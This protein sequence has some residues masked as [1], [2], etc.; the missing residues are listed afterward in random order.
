MLLTQQR[1][2]S[3]RPGGHHML[4]ARWSNTLR[5]KLGIYFRPREDDFPN[6]IV[7][8]WLPQTFFPKLSRS[9]VRGSLNFRF[10]VRGWLQLRRSEVRELTVQQTVSEAPKDGTIQRLS[11][12]RGE[13]VLGQPREETAVLEMMA[14]FRT[15]RPIG[16]IRGC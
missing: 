13:R 8:I 16:V 12:E 7:S 6:S 15:A 9:N 4:R 5:N 3:N 11:I 2:G 14:P 10:K 1:P